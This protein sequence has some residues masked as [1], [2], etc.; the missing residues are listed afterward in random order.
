M[1]MNFDDREKA[2]EAKYHLDEE[3]AFKATVRRDKLLGLWVAGQIG[4][5]GGEA[6]DYAKAVV[7]ADLADAH[8]QT[9]LDKLSQDLIRH[10]AVI[11]VTDLQAQMERLGHMARQQI[12]AEFSEGRQMVSPA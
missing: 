12:E 10:R 1:P 4:L 3:L 9:M 5:A 6:E 8:H 7:A 11:T 2:F